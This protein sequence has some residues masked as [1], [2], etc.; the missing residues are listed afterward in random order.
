[1]SRRHRVRTKKDARLHE[2]GG[3]RSERCYC[4]K[5]EL[6]E[7][8]LEKS[9]TNRGDALAKFK[10]Q[11]ERGV[12]DFMSADTQPASILTSWEDVYF[13]R[14]KRGSHF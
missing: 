5:K 11:R 13:L 1:M 14:E 3:L 9:E 12:D 6:S 2:E 8:C 4:R 7:E 10:P